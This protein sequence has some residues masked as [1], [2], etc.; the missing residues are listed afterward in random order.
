MLTEFTSES[1]DHKFTKILKVRVA[2]VCFS[3]SSCFSSILEDVKKKNFVTRFV[4]TLAY[5]RSTCFFFKKKEKQ[6][7]NCFTQFC[8]VKIFYRAGSCTKYF[9][10]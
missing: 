1:F 10:K 2:K 4:K 3:F 8:R 9:E 5:L 7:V 6:E